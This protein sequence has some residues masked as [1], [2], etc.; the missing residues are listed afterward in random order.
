MTHLGLIAVCSAAIAAMR[1]DPDHSFEIARETSR[2]EFGENSD[3][4]EREQSRS[5]S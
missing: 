3:V 2:K 5:D 1:K 4:I